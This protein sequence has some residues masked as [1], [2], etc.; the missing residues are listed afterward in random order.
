MTSRASAAFL[1]LVLLATGASAQP[2]D[3]LQ[4][5]KIKDPVAL[6]GVVDLDS[7]E[8]GAAA[9]CKVSKA[10]LL[11]VRAA[12]TV[13]SA[14]NGGQPVVP[15]PHE[16]ADAGARRV[17]YKAKC[18]ATVLPDQLVT[19]QF[20]TRTLGKLKAAMLCTPAVAGAAVCGDGSAGVGEDCDGGDLGGA[21]CASAGFPNG[22]TLACAPGCTLDTSG[23]ARGGVPVTGQTTAYTADRNDGIPGAVAVPDDGTLEAG[24]PYAW[25]D[26]GD[27]TV[28]DVVTG[29]MWEKKSNDG[30][31]HDWDDVYRWSGDG[32]QETIWDWLDDVNAEGGTGF[33][34][35]ADW[36]IPNVRELES[37]QRLEGGTPAAIIPPL[38][39]PCPLGCSVLTCACTK[40]SAPGYWSSTTVAANPPLAWLVSFQ[41]GGTI[42]GTKITPTWARAVRDAVP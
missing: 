32:T 36:R 7:P 35:Y 10:A 39:T 17:C 37:I 5:F 15:L 41:L 6:K 9:G 24:T 33:A 3:H 19:D 4:C 22:G 13:V 1:V 20:G 2:A 14:S 40:S 23:C 28:T 18:P 29:L 26:N 27:G 42:S 25:V 16:G 11:C 34:G 12:K 30:S 21:T 8:L 38:H 31:L